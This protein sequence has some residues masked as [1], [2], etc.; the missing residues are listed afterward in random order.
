MNALDFNSLTPAEKGQL[1]KA[2]NKANDKQM[3]YSAEARAAY[4]AVEGPARKEWEAARQVAAVAKSAAYAAADAVFEATMDA[5]EAVRKAATDET[6]K[7]LMAS[8]EQG[9]LH[10]LH[11]VR[12]AEAALLAKKEG[13]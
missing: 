13:F 6:Y 2:T 11:D 5:A 10:F 3:E 12:A 4:Y 1:T 7:A 9:Y 8:Q